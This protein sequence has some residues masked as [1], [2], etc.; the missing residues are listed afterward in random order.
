MGRLAI[1]LS[2]YLL[3]SDNHSTTLIRVSHLGHV[4]LNGGS[5]PSGT[6]SLAS[7]EQHVTLLYSSILTSFGPRGISSSS[8]SSSASTVFLN[9][10]MYARS[11]MDNT[12]PVDKRII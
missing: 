5:L 1:P 4:N 3:R 7:Q 12:H 2:Y 11:S 8:S 6:P 9:N 10:L